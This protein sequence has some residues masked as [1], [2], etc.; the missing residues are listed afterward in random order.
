MDW[1]VTTDVSA[2]L[3]GELPNYGWIVKD[4][5]YWGFVDI[6]IIQYRTK[7]HQDQAFHPRLVIEYIVEEVLDP[8]AYIDYIYPDSAQI[9]ETI[10]FRGHGEV[11]NGAIVL[12]QWR[13]SIDGEIG[14]QAILE[15]DDLSIGRHEICFRVLDDHGNWSP[16]DSGNVDILYDET[17]PRTENPRRLRDSGSRV[18][19]SPNPF[20]P[21]TTISFDVGTRSRVVI[22]VYDLLGREVATLVDAPLAAGTHSVV[23]NGS[24]LASGIYLVNMQTD[25]FSDTRRMVLMR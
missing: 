20:N 21:S 2:F 16:E 19:L 10:T 5:T 22:R 4:E 13:S 25:N 11:A 3:S 17:I 18:Q 7:E 12:Y 1:D 24:G 9:G 23:F 14:N 15:I 8:I 6:P